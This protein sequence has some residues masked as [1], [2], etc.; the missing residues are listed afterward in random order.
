MP[1][2]RVDF[3]YQAS[4]GPELFVQYPAELEKKI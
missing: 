4:A 1:E 3:D 2:R